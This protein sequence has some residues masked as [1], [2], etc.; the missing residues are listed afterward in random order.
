MNKRE[1]QQRCKPAVVPLFFILIINHDAVDLPRNRRAGVYGE[2][3]LGTVGRKVGIVVKFSALSLVFR[4][5]EGAVPMSADYGF[6]GFCDAGVGG[7]HTVDPACLSPQCGVCI[8]P[9]WDW[10]IFRMLR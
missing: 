5:T 9:V 7:C 2:N 4:M 3:A 8:A 6:P 1:E 10:H